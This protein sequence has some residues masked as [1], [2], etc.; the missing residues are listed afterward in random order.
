MEQQPCEGSVEDNRSTQIFRI[1]HFF[2]ETMRTTQSRYFMRTTQVHCALFSV[3]ISLLFSSVTVAQWREIQVPEPGRFAGE[4]FSANTRLFYAGSQ[5]LLLS[6]NAGLNWSPASGMEMITVKKILVSPNGELLAVGTRRIS[7]SNGFVTIDELYQSI[8]SGNVWRRIED[9]LPQTGDT[10]SRSIEDVAIHQGKLIVSFESSINPASRGVYRSDNN[11]RTWSKTHQSTFLNPP[12]KLV[13]IDSVLVCSSINEIWFSK[14]IGETWSQSA[15]ADI[16]FPEGGAAFVVKSF[17]KQ[18]TVIFAATS[19]G[20]FRSENGGESWQR[21]DNRLPRQRNVDTRDVETCLAVQGRVF[22]VVNN[23]NSLSQHQG[24]MFMGNTNTPNP[25][26]V[27]I[28]D[29]MPANPVVLYLASHE[30]FLYASVQQS[31]R[32]L[33]RRSLSELIGTTSVRNNSPSEASQNALIS[34]FSVFPM[35]AAEELRIEMHLKKASILTLML[36]DIKGR[37]IESLSSTLSVPQGTSLVAVP[38]SNLSNG[39]YFCAIEAEGNRIV[40]SIVVSK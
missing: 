14:N 2:I 17:A 30:G 27:D 13:S 5:G 7:I 9:N 21:A 29:G 11:G 26:W 15:I 23:N 37:T 34:S 12:Q 16:R 39:I 3:I 1:T 33:W 32:R 10:A 22:A 18:G 38:I 28:N 25:E 35:P 19:D 20:L 8:D 24:V 6:R 36:F 4:L 40:R 31:P